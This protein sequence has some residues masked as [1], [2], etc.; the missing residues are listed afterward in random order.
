MKAG[1]LVGGG[2]PDLGGHQRPQGQQGRQSQAGAPQRNGGDG[3]VLISTYFLD[4]KHLYNGP[5]ARPLTTSLFILQGAQENCEFF[6]KLTATYPLN[7][8]KRCI[9]TRC[10][11]NILFFSLKFCDFSEHCQFCCSAGVLPAGVY[12]HTVTTERMAKVQNISN[13][14]KKHNI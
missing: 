4:L 7:Q 14:R 9:Y 2:G 5:L 10:S 11:L 1:V 13:L 12:T 6:S 3:D 8:S